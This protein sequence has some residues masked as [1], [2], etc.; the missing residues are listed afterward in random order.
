MRTLRPA[1]YTGLDL[2]PTGIAFCQSGTMWR[3]GL[4]ARRRR[5]SAFR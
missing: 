1:S 4:R 5:G 3:A 2:N